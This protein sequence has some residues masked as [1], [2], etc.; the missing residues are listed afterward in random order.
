MPGVRCQPGSLSCAHMGYVWSMFPREPRLIRVQ[1]TPW[2]ALVLTWVDREL[3]ADAQAPS[4]SGEA[5]GQSPC[6]SRVAALSPVGCPTVG[7]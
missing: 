5:A 6:M 4:P 1:I 3:S 2:R 7:S